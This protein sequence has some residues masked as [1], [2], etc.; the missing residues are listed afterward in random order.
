MSDPRPGRELAG[1]IGGCAVSAWRFL[2]QVSLHMSS[3]WWEHICG[4][5]LIHPQWVLTAAH[6]VEPQEL[7]AC[8]FRVQV[9]QLRLY[10]DDRLVK[11]AQIIHHPKY[12]ESLS[13]QGGEDIDLLRLEAPVALSERIHPVFLPE[14]SLRVSQGKTCWVTGWGNIWEFESLP[15][16][17]H[18]QAVA[19]PIVEN[20]ACDQRYQNFLD[21]AGRVIKDDTLC[22][23]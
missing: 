15:P 6:C 23:M 10:E 2:W 18:L 17:Y 21:S 13:A 5:L 12:N 11:V 16:P 9:G 7:E 4:G 3:H 22:A 19:V 20:E 14:A 1:I 8:T